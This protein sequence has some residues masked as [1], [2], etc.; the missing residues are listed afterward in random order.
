MPCERV[1]NGEAGA[2][3]EISP[4]IVVD[5]GVRA[6]K[7]VIKGTRVPVDVVLGRTAGG[8]TYDE[9]MREYD[10]T[11][12]QILAA[13]RYAAETLWVRPETHTDP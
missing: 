11:R 5:P 13:L 12:D 4:G 1:E 8:A 6:G 10:L 7:P 2:I 3:F 9:L